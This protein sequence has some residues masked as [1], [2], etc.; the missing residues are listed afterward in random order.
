VTVNIDRT[1]P[2][3]RITGVGTNVVYPHAGPAGHCVASDALSGVASCTL[4]RHVAGSFETYTAT[5]LDKAGN[6][7]VKTLVAH[8]AD[9]VL[10]STPFSNGAYTVHQGSR[11]TLVAAVGSQPRYINAVPYHAMPSGN[12][13]LFHFTSPNRWALGITITENR[14]AHAYWNIGVKVGANLYILTLHVIA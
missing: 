6:R 13:P 4:T 9:V 3:V 7:S 10:S 8:V 1:P 5:A 11:Y 2:T 12:G 14:H